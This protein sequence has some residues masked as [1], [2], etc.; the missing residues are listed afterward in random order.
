MKVK[1]EN[2]Q[3]ICRLTPLQEGMLFH[4][5]LDGASTAYL[6]LT[7]YHLSG[8]FDLDAFRSTWQRLISRHE[9]LRSAFLHKNTPEPV[10]VVLKERAL[11]LTF[12][13]LSQ[14]PTERQEAELEACAEREGARVFDLSS[15]SLMRFAVFQLGQDS[16]EV[17]WTYHHIIL[18]GWSLGVIQQEFWDI[19]RGIASRKP[20]QLKNPVPFSRYVKWLRAKPEADAEAFWKERFASRIPQPAFRK[21]NQA[22]G[23]GEFVRE[24]FEYRLSPEVSSG[25]GAFSQAHRV[26]LN[27]V[28]HAAWALAVRLV[29]GEDDVVFGE[30]VSGRPPEI[31]GID[32]MVGLLINAIP[33]R[34]TQQAAETMSEL[35]VRVQ[36]QA[37]DAEPFH[38]ASLPQIQSAVGAK[39]ALFDHI[40]VFENYPELDDA[41]ED[42]EA[43]TQLRVDRFQHEDHTNY[44]L[45][46][47][48]M[49]TERLGVRFIYNGSAYEKSLVR[50][51]AE[52]F[53]KAVESFSPSDDLRVSEWL[54]HHGAMPVASEQRLRVVLSA[55]FTVD[56]LQPGLEWI[57]EQFGL[58]I[59]LEVAPY[60]QVCQE[61]LDE[62]SQSATN[63]GVNI[64]LVR[65]EDYLLDLDDPVRDP[66]ERA[67]RTAFSDL[68][69]AI[70][71]RKGA[72]QFWFGLLPISDGAPEFV[73]ALQ[74]DWHEFL[75][76]QPG[77]EVVDLTGL[78]TEY[79]VGP[80]FDDQALRVGRIPFSET[81][82]A[83][84]SAALGRRLIAWQRTDFKVIA[85]DCDNTL[86]GGVCGE[87][88]PT[89]V[90]IGPNHRVLQ[91]RLVEKAAEGF[92]IVL[93]SKNQ[94]SDVWAVFEQHPEM[95][96]QRTH[97]VGSRI[98]WKP[99]SDNLRELA[100][101]LNVGLDSV[102]FL[103]DS[104]VEC[105]E[106]AEHAPEVLVVRVPDDSIE[107]SEYFSHIWAWD[108][109]RVTEE[110]RR[111]GDMMRAE[112]AREQERLSMLEGGAESPGRVE[113]GEFIRS[114]EVRVDLRPIASHQW[115]RAA[116]L[117][118]RTNQFNLTVR[119]LTETDVRDQAQSEDGFV[120]VVRV[121]DRFGDYGLAGL[122]AGRS[123][124]AGLVLDQFLLSCRVLGRGVEDAVLVALNRDL[125]NEGEV[126][127]GFRPTERNQP[128]REFL[129]R[130][131]WRSR[132]AEPESEVVDYVI[133]SV[134][135][136][137]IEPSV[138]VTVHSQPE[139]PKPEATSP[140]QSVLRDT[141]PDR[142]GESEAF[143][144]WS[145][146]EG[147]SFVRSPRNQAYGEMLRLAHAS[148]L[149]AA[150]SR[151][152]DSNGEEPLVT[153]PPF[154]A[155][156]TDTEKELV[157]IW[158]EILGCDPVGVDDD[159]FELG[160]HSLKATRLVSRIHKAF[161]KEVDLGSVFEKRT[162]RR[163]ALEIDE[164]TS[165]W[166]AI[167]RVSS[168]SESA[169]SHA[170]RRMWTLHQ[171]EE[172]SVAYNSSGFYLLGGRVDRQRLREAIVSVIQSEPVLRSV[173]CST[174]QGVRMAVKDYDEAQVEVI[175]LPDGVERVS[176]PEL[177]HF[178]EALTL[179]PF[180]LDE[181]PLFL[182]KLVVVDSDHIL[183]AL[184]MHHIVS[185]GG[186]IDLF[187]RAVMAR[188]ESRV[189]P[190]SVDGC[191]EE[192]SPVGYADYAAWH[193][194]WV[195][196]EAGLRSRDY[197]LTQLANPPLPL[198]LPTDRT[199]P[200]IQSFR[201]AN[202]SFRLAKTD[203][204]ALVKLSLAAGGTRFS[205]FVAIV[206]VLLFRLT[207]QEDVIVG[208][209]VS[210]RDHP[211]LQGVLGLLA[212]TV[213][214]RDRFDSG[215]SLCEV[216]GQVAKT[217]QQAYRHQAYPFDLVLE[218]LGL[219]R[220]LS[221]SAL[222]D[223]MINY[224]GEAATTVDTAMTCEEWALPS[225]LSRFDLTF[226]A[227]E[228]DGG[229]S[230]EL[231][232]NTDLFDATRIERMGQR[233]ACLTAHGVACS[234]QPIAALLILPES[235]L[236]WLRQ[237]F[238]PEPVP[239]T[240]RGTLV[241]QF[242]EV[243]RKRGE[244]VAIE[245]ADVV[246]SFRELE[247][248]VDGVASW[249]SDSLGDVHRRV[250]AVSMHS[251]PLGVVAMLGVMRARGIYL[252]VD[253]GYPPERVAYL[254]KD[255][256]ACAVVTDL[257]GA[258]FPGGAQTLEKL[259]LNEL[260]L[261]DLLADDS[262]KAESRHAVFDS[263][264]SAYLIYTSGSTGTPKGVSVT[265]RAFTNMIFQQIELFD[266]CP[267]DRVL[268]FASFSFD[269]SLSE[270]FMSLLAGGTLCCPGREQITEGG[271]L[272]QYVRE[273]GI[274]IATLPPQYLRALDQ[275]DLGRLKT[276][277]TAGEAAVARDVMHYSQ[278]E[279]LHYINA[280]G[281]TEC[282]VCATMF[283][284][285]KGWRGD[286][287]PIGK[288]LA[289]LGICLVDDRG[290]LV[291]VGHVGEILI[292]GEGLAEGYRGQPELTAQRFQAPCDLPWAGGRLYATGDLGAW[293]ESGDLL[294]LGRVDDQLKV[295]G[296]RVEPGEVEQ[297]MS[298]HPGVTACCVVGHRAGDGAVSLVGFFTGD[299]A[300]QDLQAFLR[301]HL[302]V[303]MVPTRLLGV[304]R[305]PVTANGKVDK[306]ALEVPELVSDDDRE[307]ARAEEVEWLDV[308]MEV[309]GVAHIGLDD[310]FFELGGDSI[311]AI[312]V[313]NR[314]SRKGYAVQVKDL[315][316]HPTV[317]ELARLVQPQ[318]SV[319]HEVR[320]PAGKT[321]EIVPL[322]PIQR[323]FFEVF[324]EERHHFNHSE[325]IRSSQ[326]FDRGSVD[327]A[328]R[329]LFEEHDQLRARF[330]RVEQPEAGR[331]QWEQLIPAPGEER[332]MYEYD[333]R[334]E[335]QPKSRVEA[336]ANELQ[337]GL[338]LADG[339]LMVV[340]LF[341]CD[342]GD[343]L[344]FVIHHLVVDG[345]SWRILLDDFLAAYQAFSTGREWTVG[346]RSAGYRAW[347]QSL[348]RLAQSERM[349]HQV[350][351]WERILQETQGELPLRAQS[352]GALRA[353][354]RH[355]VVELDEGETE[356]LLA[357]LKSGSHLVDWILAGLAK[358]LYRWS[359]SE[360]FL[361]AYE[362]HGRHALDGME[363]LDVSQTVGW[364]TNVF[365]MVIEIEP[366]ESQ[367]RRAARMRRTR[368]SVPDDGMGY[369]LLRYLSA[370][371]PSDSAL[372]GPRISFNYLGQY[373][374]PGRGEKLELGVGGDGEPVSPQARLNYDLEWNAIVMNGR[375]K[376][377]V[378]YAE[379]ALNE[380]DLT[381]VLGHLKEALTDVPHLERVSG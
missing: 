197:W 356:R 353:A 343:R 380:E 321:L 370:K 167:P 315:V 135:I 327:R 80:V 172:N 248:A 164:S 184:H 6:E 63:P 211:D 270:M 4:S 198:P 332:L 29:T 134:G 183:L 144:D 363:P 76:S 245:S 49:P 355:D 357:E 83:A 34:V 285:P 173:F 303:H 279:Q 158:S 289:N 60:H 96:L 320:E 375:L 209:V 231:T 5:L 282:S 341:R 17:I 212:N 263:D 175:P 73:R 232:Y 22:S 163:L 21:W 71:S 236:A 148:S 337:A 122:V 224:Q 104:Q 247:I 373:G 151:S 264:D 283:S 230:V 27:S 54:R 339:P 241:Q 142:S 53:E 265:H 330:R 287:V 237:R 160:G 286:R 261:R 42:E 206:K 99:K 288:P 379:G 296:Y 199:R 333:L 225:P 322:T 55:T 381:C 90:T 228:E 374:E 52:A 262:L 300:P 95:V 244:A 108:R 159:F 118:Q 192:S 180:Q 326:P 222:F 154:V 20:I 203:W 259:V 324:G 335:A 317:R 344:L 30:T 106:V 44:D 78:Q 147:F 15:D 200:P 101:E 229:L 331:T 68:R 140:L 318:D 125:G 316:I 243:A 233:L 24:C 165:R 94:A 43:R 271:Q 102:V 37:A 84:A 31:G 137:R 176:Q 275:P 152:N 136:R 258:G 346:V 70:G 371:L 266:V 16:H 242:G 139:E 365:P 274:T 345:V 218:S 3:N 359:G 260:V 10:M 290:Q 372:C 146:W 268:L 214:L 174:E 124:A 307:A 319:G 150:M 107:A 336:I 88:G 39:G 114:L 45:T 62:R 221:R 28:L 32:R 61:L 103:D 309:L 91:Q 238:L 220:D 145:E 169:L 202:Q 195:V 120:F 267:E 105:M 358:S 2:I 89:G 295:R 349:L 77:I 240:A 189:S 46:V 161:K 56:P 304:D 250:V 305:L 121:R 216:L 98:N 1:K 187:Q 153:R 181:G 109:F 368:E 11:D 133:E 227:V 193:N 113:L 50:R 126:R 141:T 59:S 155:A 269:A 170:Q 111:R 367:E 179:M 239:A 207:R 329:L 246:L 223:V 251:R 86:W 340:G 201:G 314:M 256:D 66:A 38:Y 186:S 328:V 369:G 178:A 310:S 74:K 364:F 58:P 79:S 362:T 219:E 129:E 347:A 110:D 253:P 342:D 208:S 100:A 311:R 47:Q 348:E 361:L 205:A 115:A 116:Q 14:W 272:I 75:L 273:Q 194:R 377:V 252:P 354:Q 351:Y 119:R 33:V 284:V 143:Q 292:R 215:S 338:A 378:G 302:P 19:Y 65:W 299:V 249:L 297:V 294:Y 64:V 7:R 185:D 280:Y 226:N 132:E 188:Y 9:I 25:A 26:S 117:T 257:D 376:V 157:R 123:D 277:I 234:T 291:P 87:V 196:G 69:A 182:V 131:G 12:H 48:F 301:N 72:G 204:E 166:E 281:P 162:I 255:S 138:E 352:T 308:W 67:L 41:A 57:G 235:E 177:E 128:A 149:L 313:A 312:E 191:V 23:V 82:F 40:L 81:W 97:L 130:T 85:V 51:L 306:S 293:T 35:V 276:L 366:G 298:S 360:S 36:G 18:D 92:L 334:D 350:P 13:D 323:W 8:P 168:E 190:E 210:G 325:M 278:Q 217:C 112:Q 213:A 127:I 254:L 171:L 93:A 156:D